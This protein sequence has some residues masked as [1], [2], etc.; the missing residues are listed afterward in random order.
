[1]AAYNV[2]MVS[3]EKLKSYTSIHQSVSPDD[4]QPYILQS[5]DLYL[6]NYLGATFYQQLQDQILADS[7][8]VANRYLLDNYIGTLL[9]NYGFYHALPFLKYKIFNKSILA[10]NS[11]SAPGVSIEELKFLQNE[12]RSVAENYTKLMQIFLQ[13]NQGDYPAYTSPNP[14]DGMTPDRKTPFFGGIQTNSKWFNWKKYRNYPYGTG[15]RGPAYGGGNG[16]N[17]NEQCYGCG[18]WPA[19]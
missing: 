1:M 19:N 9:C 4:L 11:E 7:V 17:S 15:E 14:L 10:P 12:V 3:E 6:Q 18:D 2:L 5:Q 13:N 8:T 16:I